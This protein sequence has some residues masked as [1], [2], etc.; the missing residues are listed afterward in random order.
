MGS[1]RP[2]LTPVRGRTFVVRLPDLLTRYPYSG[3]CLDP[4][5]SL[6][7]SDPRVLGSEGSLP[8]RLPSTLVVLASFRVSA[9]AQRMT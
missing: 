4:L 6:S 5:W 1:G 7:V 8:N 9:P 3:T 2:G